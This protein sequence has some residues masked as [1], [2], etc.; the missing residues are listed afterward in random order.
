M[1]PTE[2]ASRLTEAQ[3]EAILEMSTRPSWGYGWS[4][5][6]QSFPELVRAV[7]TRAQCVSFCLTPLGL[8]VRAMLQEKQQ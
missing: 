4:E 7:Q 8:K 1:T 2:I 3:R 5:V 6:W